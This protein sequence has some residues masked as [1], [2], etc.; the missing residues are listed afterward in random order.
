[1]IFKWCSSRFLVDEFHHHVK[2]GCADIIANFIDS[3]MALS[4]EAKPCLMFIRMWHNNLAHQS[5]WVSRISWITH[6]KICTRKR[7][8]IYRPQGRAMTVYCRD[9][10]KKHEHV[11]TTLNYGLLI[12]WDVEMTYQSFR[13]SVHSCIQLLC[14]Q[15]IPRIGMNAVTLQL[16]C[17]VIVTLWNV[18]TIGALFRYCK[19]TYYWHSERN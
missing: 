2:H 7:R 8:P 5:Y 9:L 17:K 11:I 4:T 14:F 6:L 13:E 12:V 15:P 1:M 16:N 10:F 19:L 3:Y 18:G